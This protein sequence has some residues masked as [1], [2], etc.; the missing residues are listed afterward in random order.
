MSRAL[1]NPRAAGYLVKIAGMFGSDHAGER[2]AAAKLA[3]DHVKRLGMTW[4]DV[5]RVDEDWRQMARR[6]CNYPAGLNERELKFVR[7]IARGRYPPS[8]KQLAWLQALCARFN[9]E[10]AA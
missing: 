6:C 9:D 2:A 3:D 4:G 7:D 5:I 10:A 8:D 1:L